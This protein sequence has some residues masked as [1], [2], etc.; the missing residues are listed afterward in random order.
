MIVPLFAAAFPLASACLSPA[1]C[2]AEGPE[3]AE[4]AFSAGPPAMHFDFLSK[5]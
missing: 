3:D 1:S 4:E 2:R 5:F